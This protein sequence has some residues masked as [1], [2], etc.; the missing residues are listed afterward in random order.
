L[1]MAKW[2]VISKNNKQGKIARLHYDII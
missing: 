1:S 2:V